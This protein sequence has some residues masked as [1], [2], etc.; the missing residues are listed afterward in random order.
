MGMQ[1]SF[2]TRPD[3][4]R[5]HDDRTAILPLR[6]VF[7]AIPFLAGLDK[8]FG[9]LADWPAYL[10][11]FVRDHL[12]FSPTVFVALIGVVEMTVGVLMATRHVRIA[13]QIASAWLVLIA[14]QLLLGG[15]LDVA[16]RD[17]AMAV[18]AWTLARLSPSPSPT[19]VARSSEVAA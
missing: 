13:A 14:L 11:P 19:R 17:V 18:A 10:A 12:P 7:V 1:P 16:V 5:P 8:F 6:I 2:S 3:D 4:D 9:L 15:H